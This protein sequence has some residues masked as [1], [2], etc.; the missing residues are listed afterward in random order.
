MDNLRIK[1]LFN[2]EGKI[3]VITGASGLL[4]SIYTS[5]LL[6]E[7]AWIIA[8]DKNKP[9]NYKNL[10]A[11]NF[12]NSEEDI[13][14]LKF[15]QLD[16]TDQDSVKLFFSKKLKDEKWFFN[17]VD[18]LI[19]NAS[20]VKQVGV[21]DI[22]TTYSNFEN[23]DNVDWNSYFQVDIIGSLLMSQSIIPYM[24]AQKKGVIINISSTYGCVSPDQSLYN[25]LQK[26]ENNKI[27]KP[28]GYS[29]SKSAVLNMTRH[30]A[31][32]Y[33]ENGVRV[34][35][36]TPG[37]VFAD[38]PDSFVKEYSRR[39]PMNR[40]AYPYELVGPMFFLISDASSYMTGSN[41]IVD[42]GWTA[43]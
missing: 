1:N 11:D 6:K 22:S 9:N 16:I 42:G 41:L 39:T 18:V 23:Q 31:V 8:L 28:I 7:G 35:T 3:V 5:A 4:G 36:L 27:E 32:L 34:N 21:S 37:G 10:L 15:Y 19:N 43:W 20:L 40:M 14:R 38:N 26:D 25:T 24:I 30:L 12:G 33:G 2:I 13:S 29:I 17:K